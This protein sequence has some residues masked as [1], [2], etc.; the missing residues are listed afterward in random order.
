MNDKINNQ[1][2]I[3]FI[4]RGNIH[5][6]N[7]NKIYESRLNYSL[8]LRKNKIFKK[9]MQKRNNL[10]FKNEKCLNLCINIDLLNLNI[11][12]NE[13]NKFN[14]LII[15]DDK[16]K[17]LINSIVNNIHIEIFQTDFLFFNNCNNLCHKTSDFIKFCLKN[18]Y[19]ILNSFGN[20]LNIIN[21]K[22]FFNTILYELFMTNELNVKYI[23]IKILVLYSNL[24]KEFNFFFINDMRYI[25]KLYKL[26]FIDNNDIIIEL[27]TI[28]YNIIC[29]YPNE[30]EKI[31]SISPFHTR[32]NE[33]IISNKTYIQNNEIYLIELLEILGKFIA[34]INKNLFSIYQ[35]LIFF[36]YETIL[37]NN[38]QNY[39]LNLIIYEILSK[40]SIDDNISKIIISCGL[41]DLIHKQMKQNNLK[42]KDYLFFQLQIMIN[43]LS[44]E[45]ISSYFIGKN[46]LET[47]SL[48]I[49][50]NNS[51]NENKEKDKIIYLCIYCLS[52]IGASSINLI[53]SLINSNILNNILKIIDYRKS[54]NIYFE[55]C[56]LFLNIICHCSLEDF[57]Y[58]N[59]KLKIMEFFYEGIYKSN[60]NEY[61]SICLKGIYCL[62]MRNEKFAIF[63]NIVKESL[64]QLTYNQNNEISNLS[65]LI[66]QLIETKNKTF[67]G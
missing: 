39:K 46:L 49:N 59:E 43:L 47:L 6:N 1:R 23:I 66:I 60:K 33:F 67:I 28:I 36:F 51:Y 22:T 19:D 38:N 4:K 41:G 57:N 56:T 64:S 31:I 40:I 15:D 13:I 55:T 52:N 32:L 53:H 54:N 62:I 11:Y 42:N 63:S 24:S 10:N 35:E 5:D 9:I 26:T 58:I 50:N 7:K 17:Y 27:F 30:F 12:K 16:Y 48:I 25:K 3:Q 21:T 34:L 29:D 61:L 65:E 14:H 37:N 44:I 45:Y 18:L 20:I 2:L 8:N